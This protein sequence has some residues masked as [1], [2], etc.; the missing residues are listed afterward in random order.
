MQLQ[1]AVAFGW[2]A[3]FGCPVAVAVGVAETLDAGEFAG[4]LENYGAGDE[5][6]TLPAGSRVVLQGLRSAV[7]LNGQVAIIRGFDRATSRYIVQPASGGALKKVLYGHLQPLGGGDAAM[8]QESGSEDE[9]DGDGVQ[10]WRP[11]TRVRISGL[12][13]LRALNGKV[14]VVR[15]FDLASGRYVVVVPGGG[16]PKKITAAHLQPADMVDPKKVSLCLRQIPTN[17]TSEAKRE[18]QLFKPGSKVKIAGLKSK[19]AVKGG[20]NGMVATVHCFDF[21]TGRFVVAM[22]DGSPRKIRAKNLAAAAVASK[23]A[24]V[25]KPVA[26]VGGAQQKQEGDGLAVGVKA[27]LEG[28]QSARSLNGK[29]VTVQSFDKRSQRWVVELPDGTEKRVKKAHLLVLPGSFS[30]APAVVQAGS[31]KTGLSVCNAYASHSPLQAFA[32]SQ[33]GSQYTEVVHSLPFQACQDLEELPEAQGSI[34]FVVGR[35]QVARAAFNISRLG[36]GKAQEMVVFRN[37]VNSLKGKVHEMVVNA[38][39]PKAYYLTTVNAYKGGRLLEL[40]VQRGN[41]Q[42]RLPLDVDKTYRLDREQQVQLTLTDGVQHLRLSFM[43]RHGSTYSVIA[44]GVDVGLR[45]E[46]QNVG[47][48]AHEFGAWT[49]A[50]EMTDEDVANTAPQA[51]AN[52]SPPLLFLDTAHRQPAP[53]TSWLGEQLSRL[54][55]R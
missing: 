34:S 29:V 41:L 31:G 4:G 36:A 48:I 18:S 2:L 13:S 53:K 40:H 44:T 10:R 12:V 26:A 50:E 17:A 39:D 27:T 37:D 20:W 30:K 43:P 9:G 46:P 3:S 24:S 55:P 51:Q 11:G 1:L 8:L 52:P 16:P 35:L 42:E 23:P 38:A 22:P 6:Q 21:S 32:I 7:E 15:K 19:A 14:G 5:R 28:L 45:G 47:L 33:D 49:S 25:G 54:V